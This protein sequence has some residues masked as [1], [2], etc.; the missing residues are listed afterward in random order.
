LIFIE[1]FLKLLD[2]LSDKCPE[3]I[4]NVRLLDHRQS[5]YNQKDDLIKVEDHIVYKE[6]YYSIYYINCNKCGRRFG[7]KED[8]GYHTPVY[9]YPDGL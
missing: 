5:P 9:D 2:V 4:C 8:P 6:E 1:K 3:E 7:I